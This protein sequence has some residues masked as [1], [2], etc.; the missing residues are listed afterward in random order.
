M[1]ASGSDDAQVCIWSGDTLLHTLKG[2]TREV[3][4]VTWIPAGAVDAR[5]QLASASFDACVRLWDVERGV[6]VS[7]LSEHTTHVYSVAF[8]A[9]GMM[10]AS[11][12]FDSTVVVWDVKEGQVVA[13]HGTGSPV[14]ALAWDS[15]TGKIAACL[16]NTTVCVLDVREKKD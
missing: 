16:V 10:L 6:G 12:S 15:T 13:Q 9:D 3:Y 1:L 7:V 14:Y 4:S 2:H 11:G 8:S 5:V